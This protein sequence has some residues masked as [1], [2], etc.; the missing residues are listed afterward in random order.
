[1]EKQKYFNNQALVKFLYV[2]V[3]LI[4]PSY[5]VD[6]NN[7][8]V[9]SNYVYNYFNILKNI[10]KGK[11][12]KIRAKESSQ[13]IRSIMIE[14]NQIGIL[15]KISLLIKD[16]V[17][18][19]EKISLQLIETLHTIC[20]FEFPIC[21]KLISFE[22][23]FKE[24]MFLIDPLQSEVVL[25]KIIDML[26]DLVFISNKYKAN[27]LFYILSHHKKNFLERFYILFKCTQNNSVK[28]RISLFF[29]ILCINKECWEI[30]KLV[31]TFL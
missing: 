3:I 29:I 1:M 13:F 9:I 31:S 7:L 27:E 14:T 25:V 26:I 24:L 30:M 4:N 5:A 23:D 2:I 6:E 20:S 22:S 16:S 12:R 10:N 18:V 17:N 28:L 15:S 21:E 19:C 8:L 11:I